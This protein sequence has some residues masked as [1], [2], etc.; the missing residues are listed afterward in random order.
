MVVVMLRVP[1]GLPLR[2]LVGVEQTDIVWER[3]KDTV[4]QEDTEGVGDRVGHSDAV[5]ERVIGK[6]VGLA[7]GERVNVGLALTV[8]QSVLLRDD[9]WERL[10]DAVRQED[11]EGVGERVGHNDAV[12]EKVI[13]K[14]DGMGDGERVNVGL[15]LTVLQSV[16]VRETV[17]Q[18]DSLGE[19]LRCPLPVNASEALGLSER[20]A[21]ELS[22]PV[23]LKDTEALDVALGHCE[24]EG[25]VLP[26]AVEEVVALDEEDGS[27]VTLPE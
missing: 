13:G 16:L 7:D 6:E 11:T 14:E 10:K 25:V 21:L 27:S 1:E 26:L 18:S 22:E 17:A 23:T 2:H 8:L 9:I 19:M 5:G 15:A 20:Q 12:G 3:V 24:E 4:G